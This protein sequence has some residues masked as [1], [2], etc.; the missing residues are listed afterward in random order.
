MTTT[1]ADDV[2]RRVA[3]LAAATLV[4]LL[5][6]SGCS[7]TQEEPVETST[8]GG[9]AAPP[10]EAPRP[11]VDFDVEVNPGPDAI[12]VSWSLTNTGAAPLL[13]VDRVPRASGASV[14]Y[15]PEVT[16]VVGADDGTVQVAQRLY[17]L[18]E[19]DRISY[20]QLP[21][22]GATELAP[23][24]SLERDLEVPL[25]LVRASPWGDDIGFGSIELPDPVTS[26]QYC[27]GVV[28]GDPEPAWGLDRTDDGILLNHG[29]GAVAAQ[30]VLCSDPIPLD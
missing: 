25:P 14:A 20:A 4:A 5:A 24:D 29:G 13:V 28:A 30:H 3:R 12:S 15:D 18:P 1:V 10:Q 22:A 11:D 19:G 7:D 8:E 9:P 16:Y 21:R 17:D 26:V 27:L 6:V 23:G 2:R